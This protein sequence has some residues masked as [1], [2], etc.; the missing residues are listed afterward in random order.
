[1][2]CFIK[3]GS[4][5]KLSKGILFGKNPPICPACRSYTI[6]RLT[7]RV[8]KIFDIIAADIGALL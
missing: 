8:C 6:I 2:I 7:F 4:T 3:Y 5:Y 1:M